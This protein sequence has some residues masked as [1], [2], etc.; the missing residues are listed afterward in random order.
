[1]GFQPLETEFDDVE[2]EETTEKKNIF[3]YFVCVFLVRIQ[4][5]TLVKNFIVKSQ[6]FCNGQILY[7]KKVVEVNKES[8]YTNLIQ[9]CNI[10]HYKRFVSPQII[11][12]IIYSLTLYVFKYSL[13]LK[14]STFF[15]HL[16]INV[17]F[18]YTYKYICINTRV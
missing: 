10:I 12:R 1:M 3:K 16:Y 7:G 18:I 9:R 14:I 11:R 4:T 8:L 6:L 17:R 2:M 15:H 5:V 13:Y